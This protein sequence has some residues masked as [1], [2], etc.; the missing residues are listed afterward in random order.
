[1]K[2]QI[3]LHA[4]DAIEAGSLEDGL[5]L[6]TMLVEMVE[7][8]AGQAVSLED[9][10]LA[11]APGIAKKFIYH[12][13]SA[14]KLY[15]G[16]SLSLK[17]HEH[18]FV[19]HGSICVLARAALETF[20]TFGYVYGIADR[21]IGYFRY[22]TWRLS[23]L[24]DRQGF[25]AEDTAAQGRR[26]QEAQMITLLLAE[27]QAHPHFAKIPKD[28]AGKVTGKKREWR[29]HGWHVLA[30]ECGIH[31]QYFDETYDYFCSYSH[32]SY[33]AVLQTS[34]ADLAT[35]RVM[36]QTMV[37]TLNLFMTY[38]AKF[39]GAL[40]PRAAEVLK[41]YE[42]TEAFKTWHR[43]KSEWDKRYGPEVV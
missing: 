11:E 18:A 7:S 22:L 20:V 25:V 42:D 19:P 6:L 40:F 31:A 32:A 1:M 21:E 23:G 12:V 24:N 13:H 9:R 17:D 14:Y 35:E 38:F 28:H 43:P 33:L 39:Y 36:A 27:I 3:E 4:S 26:S 10:W 5:T 37:L 34:Q 16:S 30:S 41:R 15:S 29:P 8:Q 2:E